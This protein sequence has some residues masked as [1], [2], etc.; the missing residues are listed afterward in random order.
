MGLHSV[1][2][3]ITYTVFQLFI[4]VIKFFLSL[5]NLYHSPGNLRVEKKRDGFYF[6]SLGVFRAFPCNQEDKR[7]Q[8]QRHVCQI[9]HSK[10]EAGSKR[11]KKSMEYKT[12][13]FNSTL[14]MLVFFFPFLT[15][16]CTIL[17]FFQVGPP[18]T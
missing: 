15:L 18:L 12:R 16:K 2:F 14:E 13:N 1:L 6:I 4:I 7:L 17:A 10:Q 9:Y 8:L 5:V 3:W 11:Q